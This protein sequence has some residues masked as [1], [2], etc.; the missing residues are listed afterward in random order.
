MFFPWKRRTLHSG[1]EVAAEEEQ[2]TEQWL[3]ITLGRAYE[4][5]P[6]QNNVNLNLPKLYLDFKMSTTPSIQFVTT[7]V[8]AVF[9]ANSRTYEMRIRTTIYDKK[10][11]DFNI[12]L[13]GCGT[14]AESRLDLLDSDNVLRVEFAANPNQNPIYVYLNEDLVW[15]LNHDDDDFCPKS[16]GQ[17]WWDEKWWAGTIT[18]PEAQTVEQVKMM[19]SNN[20]GKYYS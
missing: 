20:I 4:C 8:K 17:V 16:E 13:E 7:F 2:L 18:F 3:P 5:R 1:R 10:Q 15:S 9:S 19:A 11:A 6:I 12:H 14:K